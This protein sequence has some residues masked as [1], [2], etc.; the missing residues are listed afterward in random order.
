MSGRKAM[1]V[2]LWGLLG[3]VGLAGV[4][5][6]VWPQLL[7]LTPFVARVD[8]PYCSHWQ[9]F[10][11]FQVKQVRHADQASLFKQ[12]RRVATDGELEQWETPDGPYWIPAGSGGILA[13]LI[14][15]QR[16]DIYGRIRRGETVIDCGAHVGTFARRAL[17]AGAARVVAVEPSAGAVE[18]LRR[19]FAAEI[20]DGRL[21]LVAKGIW[22]GEAVLRFYVNGNGDAANSFVV[23]NQDSREVSMPVT[24]VDVL[25]EQLGLNQVDLIKADVKGATQ[26]ML[27]GAAVTL[28]R[29]KPRLALS[30]EEPPEDPAALTRMVTGLQPAYAARCGPCLVVSGLIRTDVMFY[31]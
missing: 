3:A 4:A 5:V 9:S 22:D 11:D 7:L 10:Q 1:T 18:C 23:H 14:A 21:L 24:S 2:G 27:A 12:M 15:Q 29:H 25:V 16:S 20:A 13:A 6:E 17:S 26:R 28:K 31:R 19:N 30:T 8:S